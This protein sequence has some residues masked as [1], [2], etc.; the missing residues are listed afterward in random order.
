MKIQDI[1][2]KSE[3]VQEILGTPPK[4]IVRWGITVIFISV[5]MILAMAYV[6]EYPDVVKGKAVITTENP[7][8]KVNSFASGHIEKLFFEDKDTVLKGDKIALIESTANFEDVKEV[9]S[10]VYLLDT[11]QNFSSFEMENTRKSLGEIQ[12][13]FNSFISAFNA[14]QFFYKNN[15]EA[16]SNKN[17]G[18]QLAQV[19]AQHRKLLNQKHLL[20]QEIDLL[21]KQVNQ[22]A[23]LYKNKVIS[24][25]EYENLKV[26]YFQ[27]RQQYETYKISISNNKISQANLEKNISDNSN[28][29]VFKDNETIMK[30][31]ES[32]DIL[33]SK[34]NWW[35]KKY[36]ITA[37]ISGT[38]SF[39]KIWSENQKI[40]QGEDIFTIIPEKNKLIAKIYIPLE[41]VG[42]VKEN[43][44]VLINLSSFP[45]SEFGYLESTIKNISSISTSENL[46]ILEAEMPS[47]LVTSYKKEIEFI[48]Q[49]EGTASIVTKKKRI[50]SRVFEQFNKLFEI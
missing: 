49:M 45:S 36:L 34:I 6:I 42:K 32:K 20:K 1:N 25:E 22:R 27:K 29:R 3:E 4:S 12:N 39:G 43:Q 48:P 16:E 19:K 5:L 41:G 50:I 31:E 9:E 21:S 35:K 7:P 33:I 47:K 13:E 26:T 24:K 17:I 2:I 46:Y 8:I 18:T 40:V 14:L 10:L 28:S 44:H 37:P 30:F 11:I 15:F 23:K 38:I